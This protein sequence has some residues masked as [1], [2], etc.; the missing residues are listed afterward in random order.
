VQATAVGLI[1]LEIPHDCL[2]L[3]GER[4]LQLLQ[5][6]YRGEWFF[7]KELAQALIGQRNHAPWAIETQVKRFEH[8]FRVEGEKGLCLLIARHCR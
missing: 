8:F 7:I 4:F 6:R 5:R 3:T 1:A 2:V